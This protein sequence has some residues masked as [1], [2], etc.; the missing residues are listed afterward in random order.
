LERLL[1]GGDSLNGV[2]KRRQCVC[3]AAAKLRDEREHRRGVYSL[4]AEAAD[5]H[6]HVLAQRVRET[7]SGE[8]F[9]WVGIVIGCIARDYLLQRD[10][11]LVGVERA[12]FAHLGSWLNDSVPGFQI[13]SLSR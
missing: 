12:P 2:I 10:R 9:D 7:G 6:R 3:L 8:E 1:L 4:A 13:V 11:K 5:D